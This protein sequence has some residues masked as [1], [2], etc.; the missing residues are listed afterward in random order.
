[1]IHPLRGLTFQAVRSS[2][3]F[4]FRFKAEVCWVGRKE[5]STFAHD[6]PAPH[7]SSPPC[8]SWPP[9]ALAWFQANLRR[10]GWW[11]ASCG[12]CHKL[13]QTGRLKKQQKYILLPFWRPDAQN[14]G[15]GKTTLPPKAGLGEGSLSPRPAL[16]VC[17][18]WRRRSSL[19]LCGHVDFSR[20]L[21]TPSSF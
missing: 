2:G 15:V 17:W 16:G 1:M 13:L 14:Q 9:L 19:C 10:Q 5:K 11:R 18:P 3:W 6:V 20:V 4:W 21:V 12:C 7:P 8:S